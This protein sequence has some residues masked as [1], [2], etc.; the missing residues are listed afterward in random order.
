MLI[1]YDGYIVDIVSCWIVSIL[2]HCC[3]KLAMASSYLVI[4]FP[5]KCL[6]IHWL[7]CNQSDRNA[8]S[9]SISLSCQFT[10]C[11]AFFHFFGAF[12]FLNVLWSLVFISNYT[13]H[14][15]VEISSYLVV[16]M[17]LLFF[18]PIVHCTLHNI[19]F[20]DILDLL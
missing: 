10:V 13:K 15:N 9:F 11:F 19:L 20:C 1:Y 6:N 8:K 14:Y 3:W 7:S 4:I 16:F 17:W 5:V 18:I 2:L 12:Y